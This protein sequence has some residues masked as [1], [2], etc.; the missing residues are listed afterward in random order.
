MS[1]LNV[2]PT[3]HFELLV[4]ARDRAYEQR[5]LPSVAR[6]L[7]NDALKDAEE[8][9]AQVF[10]QNLKSLLLSPPLLKQRILGLDPGLRNCKLAVIDEQGA[11]L[12]VSLCYTHDRR[13]QEALISLLSSLI[14]IELQR[15]QSAMVQAVIMRR[16]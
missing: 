1:D 7:W 9:S 4:E 16:K 8:R 6:A 11:V 13:Q 3:S 2:N 14:S 12:N 15:S 10:S 5:L